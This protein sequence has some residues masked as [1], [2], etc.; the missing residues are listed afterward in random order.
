METDLGDT[1][2]RLAP[3]RSTNYLSLGRTVLATGND[4][5][6]SGEKDQGAWCYQTRILSLYRWRINGQAPEVSATSGV[7]QHRWMGYYIAPL[8][9]CKETETHDCDPAQHTIELKLTRGI[10]NGFWETAELTNYTQIATTVRLELEVDADFA[11]PSEA[12]GNKRQ[13]RGALKKTWKK[14]SAHL[15]MLEFDYSAEHEFHH[16]GNNGVARMHRAARLRFE[17]ANGAPQK[18]GRKIRFTIH[19]EPHETWRVFIDCSVALEG[20]WLPA[21][22]TRNAAGDWPTKRLEFLTHATAFSS[23]QQTASLTNV[24]LKTLNRAKED[25]FALRLFDLDCPCAWTMAGGVPSYLAFFGRDA[26]AA[27]WQSALLTDKPARGT[28]AQLSAHQAKETNAWRDEQPGRMIHELHTNPLAVLNFTPHAR[29]YGDVTASIHFPVLVT[30][31]WHWTGSKEAVQPYIEPALKALHWADENANVYDD[32]FYRYQTR[33]EQGEKNQGWKDSDDAIVTADG[34]QVPD[35]LG[36]CEMQAFAYASKLHFAELLWWFDE[37]HLAKQLYDEAIELKK[38]FNDTFWMEDEQ[39]FGMAIDSQGKLVR[40]IASDPGHCLVSGIVDESLVCPM[41]HRFLR[42][43]LFSGWGIRSLSANHPAFNPYA[44]HRGT[45]WPVE[46]GVFVL[47]MARYGLQ[48]EAHRLSKAFFEA[49]SLFDYC[50]LPEVFAGHQR[51]SNHPFP[52]LYPRANSPQA[53]SSSAP[54]VVL[55]AL[56]GIFPYAPLKTLLLDPSLPEW[57]PSVTLSN[58]HI[59]D[60]IVDLRFERGHDG[61]TDYQVEQLRGD[62]H[63]IRQPSPWSLTTGYGE[64]VRDLITSLLPGH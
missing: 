6:I 48:A 21:I 52:G 13:Q 57:L 19:L 9:N 40:S 8:A 12:T 62:L 23:E 33:S 31:L 4:G 25:L 49:A 14:A 1:L 63:I 35:P 51:D 11:D 18:A 59:G 28:L 26:I 29:Y 36:T 34:K 20:E 43:D 22:D 60:A 54:F 39:F 32:G 41:T 53:W 16:Q 7:S 47:A 45:V 55:Q 38:R 58:L 37:I 5:F 24:V 27:S 17:I 3:R 2:I 61:R 10:A 42:N 46:N 64:R 44:Y 50:R 15:W 30:A 56:L